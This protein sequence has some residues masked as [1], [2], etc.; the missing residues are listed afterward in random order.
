MA[1]LSI[2]T[3]TATDPNDRSHATDSQCFTFASCCFV[4]CFLQRESVE[5]NASPLSQE[6]MI[7]V[8]EMVACVQ[9]C[10]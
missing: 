10:I 8:A 9:D 2:V 4:E 7:A 6:V 3:N 1:L 5:V